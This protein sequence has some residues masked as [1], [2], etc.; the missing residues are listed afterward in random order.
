[1][2]RGGR[3]EDFMVEQDTSRLLR[4][5][6]AGVR[7]GIASIED[8]E[9]HAKGEDMKKILSDC[10]EAH[11]ALAKDLEK[12]LSRFGDEGK[13][14]NPIAK[15]MSWMKTELK[16]AMCEKDST[17]ADLMVDGCNMGIKSLSRYL[18]EYKAADEDAKT[19]AKRLVALEDAL[20]Q[21]LRTYL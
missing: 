9:K 5:C 14:P 2:P 16:L 8:V 20:A 15:G 1:M 4:E 7:M 13:N 17:I 3:M 10:K 11:A 6:D 19:I 21:D 18:N 12:A